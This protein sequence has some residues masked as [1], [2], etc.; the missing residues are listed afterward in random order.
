[1]IKEHSFAD[2]LLIFFLILLSGSVLHVGMF[3][4]VYACALLYVGSFLIFKKNFKRKDLFLVASSLLFFIFFFVFNFIF[5]RS[6]EFKDYSVLLMQIFLTLL[7]LLG[8]KTAQANFKLL[9]YKTLKVIIILSIIGF[10]LSIL[11]IG[12]RIDVGGSGYAVYT[13]FGLFYYF[14]EFNIG[15]LEIYRNQGI[16]WEPGLLAIYA[17]I[18]LYISLFVYP[19]KKD[20]R[21]AIACILTTMSTTGVFI[22]LIQ[23]LTFARKKKFSFF[24]KIGIAFVILGVFAFTLFSFVD[25]KQE[26]EDAKV[27]SYGLRA[28]DLYSGAMVAVT[29]PLFGT[30][31]NKDA[32][33][34]ERNKFIPP[35][36]EPIMDLIEERGNSNSLLMLFYSMGIFAGLFWL[37]LLYKQDVFFESPKLFFVILLLGFF[38]EPLVFMPFFMYFTITGF[39]RIMKIKY[40]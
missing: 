32:F 31:L 9:L 23:L 33:I 22:V 30:G 27:S 3:T 18:F 5:S 1:M 39:Q 14:A 29:N 37:Y 40:D 2:S 4:I 25:K 24:Q 34:F 36:I 7:I 35:E 15:F 11:K 28:F 21:L 19:N 20:S 8:L 17:N 13:I 26:G 16:F 10:F 38:S 6:S 12:T